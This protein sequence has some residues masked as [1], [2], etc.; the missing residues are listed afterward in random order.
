[1]ANQ[2]LIKL[3]NLNEIKI[4]SVTDNAINA[5]KFIKFKVFLSFVLTDENNLLSSNDCKIATEKKAY[6]N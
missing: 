1:M 5:T 3:R 4:N 2:L 6:D